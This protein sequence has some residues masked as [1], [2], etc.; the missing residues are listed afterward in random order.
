MNFLAVFFGGGIGSLL[1]YGVQLLMAPHGVPAT[2]AVNVVGCLLIGCLG[3]AGAKLGW[4]DAARLLLTTG[5]CGG[6]TTF[7][8]FGKETAELLQDGSYGLAILYV[9]GSVALGVAAAA[10]GLWLMK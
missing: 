7:S 1:R 9:A 8:T 4:N 2:L 6:F 10:L 3:A 5:L